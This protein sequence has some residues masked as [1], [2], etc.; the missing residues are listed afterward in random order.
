VPLILLCSWPQTSIGQAA[1]ADSV[2]A[3]GENEYGQT[4]V[5][6]AAQNGVVAIA[7]GMGHIVALKNDGTV[8]AWGNNMFGQVT[9]TPTTNF[10]YSATASPVTLGGRVLS[11]VTAIAAVRFQTVALIGGVQLLPSLNARPN[12][13]ELILSW[14]TNAPGF[15]LQSAPDLTPPVTWIDST[16]VPAVIGAQFTLT[17]TTSGGARYYR[18]RKM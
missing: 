3:W 4:T 15:T 13:D 8:V 2:V 9:G 16:S 10:P 7:A 5:P 18:L 14:P 11:G 1:I 17:N 12:G 6:V